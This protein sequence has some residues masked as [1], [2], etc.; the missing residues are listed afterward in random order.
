M[1][2]TIR[3]FGAAELDDAVRVRHADHYRALA[4]R[5]DHALREG[6]DQADWLARLDS[7]HANLRAALDHRPGD[8]RLAGALA[9]FWNVRGHAAEGLERLTRALAHDVSG[10]P[11][12]KALAGASG[13]AWARGDHERSQAL[14]AEALALYRDLGDAA[15]TVKAL[16]NLGYAASSTGDLERARAHYEEAL[17]IAERPRDRVVA[18]NCLSDLALRARELDRARDLS[19]QALAAAVDEESAGVATFNLGYVALV[20]GRFADAASHLRAAAETFDALGDQETVA[21]ALD[22]LAIAIADRPDAAA[23]LLGAAAARREA[24]GAAASFEDDLRERGAAAIRAR[25][26]PQAFDDGA[27][28]SLAELLGS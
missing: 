13:L 16:A 1:L 2:E 12:A 22:G 4:E 17:E 9:A 5:A 20:D 27:G 24:V 11:R 8:V 28:L 21:L 23:R 6:G 3:E 25:A 10:A 7:E 19:E 18:L 26:A 15:G 14:A